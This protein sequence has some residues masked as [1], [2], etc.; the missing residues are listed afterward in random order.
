MYTCI[1][2]YDRLTRIAS[3]SLLAASYTSEAWGRY[4]HLGHR[5]P[6]HNSYR[7]A[8]TSLPTGQRGLQ[9]R[10]SSYDGWDH[11]RTP[12]VVGYSSSIAR[13]HL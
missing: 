5:I 11:R 7:T 1:N 2:T 6:H 8:P 9:S 10:T 3:V 4:N 12:L 13:F